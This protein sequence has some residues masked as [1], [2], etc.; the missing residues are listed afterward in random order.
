MEDGSEDSMAAKGDSSTYGGQ[1]VVSGL[2]K[3]FDINPIDMQ[4]KPTIDIIKALPK[5]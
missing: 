1:P 5:G 4:S 3:G 2:V